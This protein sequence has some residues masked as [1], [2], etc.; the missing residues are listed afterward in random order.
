MKDTIRSG[1][2]KLTESQ[3]TQS[4]FFRSIYLHAKQFQTVSTMIIKPNDFF[5]KNTCHY[6][7][8]H[9]LYDFL[10]KFCA[11]SR[12]QQNDFSSSSTV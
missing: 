5:Q 1:C 11:S 8:V 12:L 4:P 2:I 7:A 3:A 9:V 6:L 10:V